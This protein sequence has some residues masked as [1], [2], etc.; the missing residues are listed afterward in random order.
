MM[1]VETACYTQYEDNHIYFFSQ[2]LILF[3]VGPRVIWLVF[4]SLV[5]ENESIFGGL[6][7]GGCKHALKVDAC[8]S[9]YSSTVPTSHN[10]SV[11]IIGWEP[12]VEIY[13]VIF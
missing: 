6:F 10:F 12:T 1:V 4:R 11:H 7:T 2:A 5:V 8:E 13:N 9:V 3:L